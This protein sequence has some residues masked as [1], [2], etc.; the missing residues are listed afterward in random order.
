MPPLFT[1]DTP[2]RLDLDLPPGLD[3]T[4]QP[5]LKYLFNVRGKVV[6]NLGCGAGLPALAAAKLG[7][8]EVWASDPSVA[9]VDA[10]RANAARN[11][12]EVHAKVGSAF[13]V[14]GGRLFDL[15]VA[16]LPDR[17]CPPGAPASAGAGLDGLKHLGPLLRAAPDHLER[18]G[19]VLTM[20]SSLADVKRFEELLNEGFRFRGL[21]PEEASMPS[22][23]ILQ[24]EGL[25]PYLEQ[26]RS[27]GCA[28][29]RVDGERVVFTLRPFLAMRR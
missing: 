7:A 2:C 27:E 19:Q 23:K 25:L 1:I 13:E 18:G 12:V 6:L 21:P 11:G 3:V 9:A 8:S 16:V 15:V 29:F 17:P 20:L 22:E 4:G 24:V 10:L 26:R 28:E 14:T 5:L